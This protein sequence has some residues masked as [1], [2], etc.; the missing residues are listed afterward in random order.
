MDTVRALESDSQA[1]AGGSAGGA[2]EPREVRELKLLYR[3]SRL[4]EQSLDLAEVIEPVLEAL[5]EHMSLHHGTLTLLNRQ[6]G[7]IATFAAHGASSEEAR[8]AR[9][10]LGEGVTGRV[11]ESGEP[12]VIPRISESDVFL[13]RTRRRTDVE[14]E[15]LLADAPPA[16][17]KH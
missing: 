8:R 1:R 7:D 17:P 10:R 2:R 11:V 5:A 15:A 16:G 4:L 6:T 9:Y 12:A 13:N 3:L 14:L